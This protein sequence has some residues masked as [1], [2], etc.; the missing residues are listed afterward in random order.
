MKLL[1]LAILLALPACQV[2]ATST[3]SNAIPASP[4]PAVARDPRFREAEA[5]TRAFAA[6][7]LASYDIRASVAGAKCD[8]LFVEFYGV[9]MLPEMIEAFHLGRVRYGEIFPGGARR[10]IAAGGFRGVAYLD[11]GSDADGKRWA[12]GRVRAGEI[13]TLKKCRE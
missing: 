11:A 3:T 9:N 12:Y 8:V 5:I 1:L 2:P 4:T 13:A 10:A 6:S 7:S